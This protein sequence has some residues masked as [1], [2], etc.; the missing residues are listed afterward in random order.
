MTSLYHTWSMAI[1]EKTADFKND[2]T[3]INKNHQKHP[4]THTKTPKNMMENS[5]AFIRSS[6]SNL[7]KRLQ[8]IP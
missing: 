3:Q 7:R 1:S 5:L 8:N 2:K 4:P 6:K